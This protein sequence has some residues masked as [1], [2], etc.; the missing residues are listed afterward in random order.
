MRD[1]FGRPSSVF[2][3]ASNIFSYGYLLCFL[4]E[5]IKVIK[6]E[7]SL[8]QDADSGMVGLMDKPPSVWRQIATERRSF[9]RDRKK[10]RLRYFGV[11][12]KQWIKD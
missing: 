7:F 8:A 1:G 11:R 5:W 3:R 6:R 10:W 9:I 4:I 2:L 12:M